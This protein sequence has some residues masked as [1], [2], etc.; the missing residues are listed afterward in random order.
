[1]IRGVRQHLI[2]GQLV[3]IDMNVFG[4][5]KLLPLR[6]LTISFPSGASSGTTYVKFQ[7]DFGIQYDDPFSLW[8][9]LLAQEK[10]LRAWS[11]PGF[12]V[13]TNSSTS[14][15]YGGFGQFTLTSD[16][17]STTYTL[18]FGYISGTL[19]VFKTGVLVAVTETDPIAGSFTFAAAPLIT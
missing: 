12:A 4:V 18:P 3:E 11:A 9:Y 17:T 1:M 13:V 19:Q 8:A 2:A 16:G 6:H 15:P 7:G 14:A 10:R 5:Y